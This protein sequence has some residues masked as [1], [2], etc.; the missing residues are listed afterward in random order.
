MKHIS[1][2]VPWHDRKWDGKVCDCPT[3]NPFC[4]MLKNI[5]DSKDCKKEDELASKTW[6]ELSEYELPACKGEN[7]GFMT[8]ESYQRTFTHVY[9]NINKCPSQN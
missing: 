1:I 6:N 7:G 2:R 4:M 5:C 8:N 3:N 9:K